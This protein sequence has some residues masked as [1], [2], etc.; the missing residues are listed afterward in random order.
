MHARSELG[1]LHCLLRLFLVLTCDLPL[2]SVLAPQP[3]TILLAY[4]AMLLME[5][6]QAGAHI[7]SPCANGRI[8]FPD[9][10]S[11]SLG[12]PIPRTLSETSIPWDLAGYTCEVSID[13]AHAIILDGLTSVFEELVCS[14]DLKMLSLSKPIPAPSL[15][16]L[17]I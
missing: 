3:N 11:P 9:V 2:R 13:C 10:V 6:F 16:Y 4:N 14:C 12:L 15:A 7:F 17:G 8:V 5:Q 1:E